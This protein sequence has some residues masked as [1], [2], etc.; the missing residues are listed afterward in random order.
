MI[1]DFP[2]GIGS[3]AVSKPKPVMNNISV[4]IPTLGR[5]T[6]ESSLAY[7]LDGAF[8]P[9]ELI[10]VD[11]GQNE[12]TEHL[13][14]QSTAAGVNAHY[15]PSSSRGRAAGINEGLYLVRTRFVAITDDDC[16]VDFRWLDKMASRLKRDPDMIVTGRV[17]LAGKAEDEFSTVLSQEPKIY[18][19]PTLKAH[20]FIGGNVGMSMDLVARIG[21]FDE[22]PGLSSAEDSDYGYRAL[23]MGIPIAYD[24]EICV[25]HYHWR[26]AVQ[27]AERHASYARSQGCFYGTHLRA[28]DPI[29]VAQALRAV[30]RSPVRWMWGLVTGN[31]E[32]AANGRAYTLN[33]LPGIV[34]GLRREQR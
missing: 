29:I 2:K 9:S 11:Q 23:K 24:P 13:L 34:A 5:E 18:H 33:M 22:H 26:D 1:I 3:V 21:P 6:L 12:R 7:I 31:P 15:V 19:E 16:F 8:W 25:Y 27:R 14:W 20:P 32:L 4:L 17:E 28:L 10:V 30:L